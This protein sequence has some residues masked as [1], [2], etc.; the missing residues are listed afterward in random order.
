MSAATLKRS[1]EYSNALTNVSRLLQQEYFSA[2][3]T[4]GVVPLS[5]ALMVSF[6]S[7]ITVLG[8]SAETYIHGTQVTLLYLGGFFGTPIVLYLYLP[9]FMELNTMSVYEVYD[10]LIN[11]SYYIA[12]H[13]HNL[14]LRNNLRDHFFSSIYELDLKSGLDKSI[15]P[16]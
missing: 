12:N 6:M 13:S 7:A 4:M 2:N 3:R 10:F 11:Q 16:R 8:I 15:V 9:V 14:A 5:I 1:N